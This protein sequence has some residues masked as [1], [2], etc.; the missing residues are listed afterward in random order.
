MRC[1]LFGGIHNYILTGILT[2]IAD[3][4]PHQAVQAILHNAADILPNNQYLSRFRIIKA[5]KQFQKGLLYLPQAPNQT[6]SGKTSQKSDCDNSRKAQKNTLPPKAN[7][8][9]ICRTACPTA[10]VVWITRFSLRPAKIFSNHP[11]D[12]RITCQYASQRTSASAFTKSV[13]IRTIESKVNKIGGIEKS[14]QM[15]F[16]NSVA[17]VPKCAFTAKKPPRLPLDP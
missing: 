16:A 3:I 4:I 17:W 1:G 13:K 12:C 14:V 8:L 6:S 5:Q 15:S 10:E 7:T 11:T 2:T 9:K